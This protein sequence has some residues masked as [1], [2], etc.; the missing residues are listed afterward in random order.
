MLSTINCAANQCDCTVYTAFVPLL[1][2]IVF[3]GR[4]TRGA[5][6]AMPPRFQIYAFAPPPP[7][8][9]TRNQSTLAVICYNIIATYVSFFFFATL[10]KFNFKN[11][12]TIDLWHVLAGTRVNRSN[13][14]AVDD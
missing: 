11:L 12:S 2:M 5:K 8:F 4:G 14:G 1:H 7:D 6:G 9:H 13:F 3:I 10:Y